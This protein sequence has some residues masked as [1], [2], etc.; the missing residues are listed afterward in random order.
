M[1]Y[2]G[3]V[4]KGLTN[5]EDLT[6]EPHFRSL[7]LTRVNPHELDNQLQDANKKITSSPPIYQK[8]G[9]GWIL[10]EI[11]YMD[12]SIAQYTPLKKSSY[13]P[14]PK[15]LNTKKAINDVKILTANI[16]CG[17][18]LHLFIP[19]IHW[20][21]NPER[22]HH[23]QRFQDELNFDGIGFP[24]AIDEVGKFERQNNISINVFGFEDV[25]FPI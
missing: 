21:D 14:L 1:A 11:L 4:S 7:C 12:L 9:R 6:A 18:F 22:L 19:C 13:I 5:G 8:E 15:K 24:L 20:K 17:Q 25:L 3:S 10:D 2:L 16:L 23:Y